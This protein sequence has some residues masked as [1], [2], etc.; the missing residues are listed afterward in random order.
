[1]RYVLGLALGACVAPAPDSLLD[2]D[3]PAV[4][5]E[6]EAVDTEVEPVEESDEPPVDDTEPPID[7][8]ALPPVATLP[9]SAVA[10]L[11]VTALSPTSTI[12]AAPSAPTCERLGGF[13]AGVLSFMA[14]PSPH[15]TS[16]SGEPALAGQA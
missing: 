14:W 16:F 2:K 1:M 3:D 11:A 7:W 5:S 9:A 13:V 12:R 10:D 6:V 4:D 8:E 15:D